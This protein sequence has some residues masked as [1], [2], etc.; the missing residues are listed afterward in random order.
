MEGLGFMVCSGGFRAYGF[1]WRVWGLWFSVE[2]L[3]F[4]VFSGGFR[5]GGLGKHVIKGTSEDKKSRQ[6][7]R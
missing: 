4:M 1:Q 3:G 2:G 7:Q 6:K 5:V